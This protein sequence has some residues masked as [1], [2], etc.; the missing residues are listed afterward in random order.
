MIAVPAPQQHS[1]TFAVKPRVKTYGARHLTA[2]FIA[3]VPVGVAEMLTDHPVRF[4]HNL[5]SVDCLRAAPSGHP[6]PNAT[7][8][9]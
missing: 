4:D 5:T 6:L 8:N 2:R 3:H 7:D 9:T 1:A